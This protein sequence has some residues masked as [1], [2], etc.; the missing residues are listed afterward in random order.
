MNQIL[1]GRSYGLCLAKHALAVWSR[2]QTSLAVRSIHCR[3]HLTDSREDVFHI[4]LN[5]LDSFD[6]EENEE[7]KHAHRIQPLRAEGH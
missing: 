7:I 3:R 4:G 5:D 6:L 2:Q 1:V